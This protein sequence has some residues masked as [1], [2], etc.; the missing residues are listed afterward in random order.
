MIKTA[1]EIRKMTKITPSKKAM[2]ILKKIGNEIEK[3]AK[4]G[5][6]KAIHEEYRTD[7]ITIRSVIAELQNLG[8][9]T[10]KMDISDPR[11][12]DGYCVQLTI[13]W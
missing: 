7:D 4:N 13:R 6:H 9:K 2:S 1:E 12:N 11:E 3:C 5:Q 8:Y 10:S